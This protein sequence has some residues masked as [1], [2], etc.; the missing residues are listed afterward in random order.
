MTR[1][2]TIAVIAIMTGTSGSV[3]ALDLGKLHKA[4]DDMKI[5]YEGRTI[6]HIEDM[7][8]INEAGAKIGE[9]EDV[10]IN[11][12]NEI[13]AVVVDL[14]DTDRD[15]IVDLDDLEIADPSSKNFVSKRTIVELTDL[16]EW[17]D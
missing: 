7:D 2:L 14:K 4:D 17:R 8:V 11:D 12:E 10:L 3:W 1:M 6:D 5:S 16:P 15:V 9:V 13:V